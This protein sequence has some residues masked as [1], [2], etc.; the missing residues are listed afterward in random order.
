MKGK[1]C[2][3][4]NGSWHNKTCRAGVCYD[5]VTPDPEKPGSAFRKPCQEAPG[6]HGLKVLAETGPQGT[7]DKREW[8]TAEDLAAN[9]KAIEEAIERMEKVMPL[10]ARVKEEHAGRS[11]KGV[12]VCP[13]CGGHLHLSHSGYNGHVWGK[14]ETPGCLGWME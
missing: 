1:T 5:D 13:C 9:E 11:W 2:R 7:C 10:V 3:H 4:Y 8:E 6:P 14:C 12:E